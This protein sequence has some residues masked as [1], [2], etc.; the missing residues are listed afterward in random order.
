MQN[1]EPGSQTTDFLF[2]FLY[3]DKIR[4][5]S[6]FAQ[7]F[8][9]GVLTSLKNSTSTT[10]S[11][12]ARVEGGIPAVAKA[13]ASIN[14]ALTEQQEHSYNTEWSLP[15]TLLDALDERGFIHRDAQ[16]ASVGS[17]VLVSGDMQL[18]DV[19]MLQRIWDPS[20]KIMLQEQKVTHQNKASL[21]ALKSQFAGFGDAIR[22][23]PPEPQ[24]HLRDAD[25]NAYWAS[26]RPEHMIVNA[27]T[28][29]LA[30]GPF[31]AGTWYALAVLDARPSLHD[32]DSM[33]SINTGELG[34]TMK[35]VLKLVRRLVGRDE[36]S[37]AITPIMIFRKT[38]AEEA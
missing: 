34:E 30:H 10:E 18:T 16:R 29:A 26:L 14:G 28:L 37:S 8:N 2:D 32:T 3:V 31:L 23:M 25:G 9:D 7:L 36:V 6:W 13:G 17:L 15:L 35:E 20:I 1:A 24:V 38:T 19:G 12:V 21:A 22:A 4:V 5:S 27:T 11:T 33:Q